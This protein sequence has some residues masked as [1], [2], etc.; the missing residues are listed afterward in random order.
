MGGVSLSEMNGSK[1]TRRATDRWRE[2]KKFP[3][4]KIASIWKFLKCNLISGLVLQL[5]SSY[6]KVPEDFFLEI[7]VDLLQNWWTD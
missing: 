4:R 5:D 6:V 7:I 1:S 2:G 3:W